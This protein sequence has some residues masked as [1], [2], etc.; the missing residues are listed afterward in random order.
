[1]QKSPPVS[2]RIVID[3]REQI[4]Y[5]FSGVECIVKGL[6][7]GDYSIENLEDEVAVER[8]NLSDAYGSIGV[9]RERFERELAR[10]S[11]MTYAAIVIESSLKDFLVA[12][13]Y[14]DLNPKAAIGSLLA[15]SVK[16]RLPIFFCGDRAHAQ[17]TTLKLL[18]KYA[19]YKM[20]GELHYDLE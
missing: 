1:M 15:W 12:P 16:F 3:S 10:L 2:L 6:S 20:T 5:E 9:G 18:E 4:P 11:E 19:K 7:S 14:S 13:A 8:K 17:A